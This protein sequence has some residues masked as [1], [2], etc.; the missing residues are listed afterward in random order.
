[1]VPNDIDHDDVDRGVIACDEGEFAPK[2]DLKEGEYGWFATIPR[3]TIIPRIEK[4]PCGSRGDGGSN[5]TEL[6]CP[7]RRRDG[8]D[9]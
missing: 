1:M 4:S 9:E 7:S 3:I 2:V 5:Q 8:L 6:G